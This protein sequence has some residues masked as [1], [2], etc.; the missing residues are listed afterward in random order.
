MYLCA[1]KSPVLRKILIFLSAFCIS[2]MVIYSVY[3][4]SRAS[5][6]QSGLVMDA[7]DLRHTQ[8][9]N[10]LHQSD[11][12]QNIIY[13]PAVRQAL[14]APLG[15]PG[16]NFVGMQGTYSRNFIEKID[17]AILHH[18]PNHPPIDFPGLQNGDS[19]LFSYYFQQLM[20]PRNFFWLDNWESFAGKHVRSLILR[21][22]IKDTILKVSLL[23]GGSY[24]RITFNTGNGVEA[25]YITDGAE[26][27][28]QKY[29]LD[30]IP[31]NDSITIWNIP[32]KTAI[33]LPDIDF[34]FERHFKPG[35]TTVSFMKGHTF[36]AIDERLK[37]K[38]TVRE[39]APV[40]YNGNLI[41]PAGPV[42]FYLRNTQVKDKPVYF[43][44]LIRNP[45]VLIVK[46]ME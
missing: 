30:N 23:D 14:G 40:E 18:F 20:M 34:Y 36:K 45:E 6:L 17:E 33:L 26:E 8:L 37:A 42:L 43:A 9:E 13:I 12:G 4:Y 16:D 29:L 5:R 38:T 15:I 27:Y 19:V 10:I 25:N 22:E 7:A 31:E 32:A 35:D 3:Y 21:P 41:R 44:M 2:F 1:F 46:G 28:F 39:K 24:K 11:T